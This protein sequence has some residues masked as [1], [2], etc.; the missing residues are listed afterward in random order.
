MTIQRRLYIS[1]ILMI[2]LPVVIT[3][4][5]ASSFSYLLMGALGFSLSGH[6]G[7]ELDF[8]Q[9]AG[10]IAGSWTEQSTAAEIE[11]SL[12]DVIE[13]FPQ[14]DT[15]ALVIWRDSQPVFTL[16][17]ATLLP[18]GP[19]ASDSEQAFVTTIV[20]V[21]P[22]TL[23]GA[24]ENLKTQWMS[25]GDVRWRMS[26]MALILL[27]GMVAII[28]G[29]NLF[30]TRVNFRHVMRPLS[31]LTDGVR[32][33]A[34]GNLSYRIA[35]EGKD[36]LAPII[37]DFN[38]M[39]AR[40]QTMVAARQK[41]DESRRELIAG[42][43]HD[44]RT[45]LTSIIGYVEG[46]EKGVATD[47]ATQARYLA[48][49]R[50]QAQTLSHIINQLFLFTKLDADS[51]PMRME[52]V[53][54]AAELGAYVGG[55]MEPYAERGLAIA[56]IP[57]D[58]P[59]CVQAD[60]VQLRNVWTN[61]LENSAKYAGKG[62]GRMEIRCGREG[63]NAVITMTDDG[64]GVDGGSLDK[65]FTVFY[66]SDAS[67]RSPQD[68]SGLGLAI[69]ARIMQRLGGEITA[70]NAEPGGLMIRIALPI[71]KEDERH[72]KDPDR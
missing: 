20:T 28:I 44:L 23:A 37:D 47:P 7:W 48:V 17:D 61:I 55:A 11:A 31:A 67:R 49:I 1:N 34:Q 63:G 43:S 66:R 70:R 14:A 41:D 18:A 3:A 42:I 4:V 25:G 59:L 27:G 38:D 26:V 60:R 65:L 39:A 19:A 32:Q 21:G 22:Y 64:P 15:A 68:G 24:Q 62:G 35:Y 50:E 2:V 57:P 58:K 56:F 8:V 36:E 40:L 10:V 12:A 16:G 33:V 5:V 30:L 6:R 29:V 46:L 69:S 52:R 53:E 9:D 71:V 45:P 72:A 51:F 13:D 54:L